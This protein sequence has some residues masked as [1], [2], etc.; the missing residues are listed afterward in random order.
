MAYNRLER[1]QPS[2]TDP[3]P[4]VEDITLKPAGEVTVKPQDKPAPRPKV[5]IHP[6]RQAPL[7]PEAQPAKKEKS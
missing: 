3:K 4:T 5:R 2:M 7:V 6:R 1:G